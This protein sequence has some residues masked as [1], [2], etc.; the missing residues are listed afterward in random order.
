MK[1]SLISIL[2]ISFNL[3]VNLYAWENRFTHPAITEQA[4][5]NSAAKVIATGYFLIVIPANAGIHAILQPTGY[6]LSQ[7]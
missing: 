5:D 2:V 4:V 7:V 6:L 1:K 3:S